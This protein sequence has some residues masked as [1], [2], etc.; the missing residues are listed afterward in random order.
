[1]GCILPRERAEKD[2]R[3]DIGPVTRGNNK[4]IEAFIR[5]YY[6]LYIRTLLLLWLFVGHSRGL[7]LLWSQSL[8]IEVSKTFLVLKIKTRKLSKDCLL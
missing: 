5:R 7:D 8:T 2:Y 4:R 3:N 1:M 6:M